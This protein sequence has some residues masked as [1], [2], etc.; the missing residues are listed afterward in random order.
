[1]RLL[2][3]VWITVIHYY[4]AVWKADLKHSSESSDEDFKIYHISPKLDLLDW[5]LPENKNTEFK[6]LN[7][8][9]VVYLKDLPVTYYPIRAPLEIIVEA[10]HSNVKQLE[11]IVAVNW[12]YIEL[13]HL[14]VGVMCY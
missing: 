4:W 1:M 14:S 7:G 8:Q 10:L 5:L 2:S 3:L 11:A 9:A 6:L 13:I 12:H